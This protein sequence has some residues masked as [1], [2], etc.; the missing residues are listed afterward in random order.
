MILACDRVSIR[1]FSFIGVGFEFPSFKNSCRKFNFIF[2]GVYQL[3]EYDLSKN[4][5]KET[6]IFV[7]FVTESGSFYKSYID[8]DRRIT[9]KYGSVRRCFISDC[10]GGDVNMLPK[11]RKLEFFNSPYF[12]FYAT[13]GFTRDSASILVGNQF[14]QIFE[15]FKFKSKR[16]KLFCSRNGRFN[17]HRIYTIYKLYES[18]LID[19]GIVSALFYDDENFSRTNLEDVNTIFTDKIDSEFYENEVKPNLP[20]AIDDL[21]KFD[22]EY[23]LEVRGDLHYNNDFSD[24]YFDLVTENTYLGDDNVH[25]INTITEK[26]IKPFLYYQI[27][28]FVAQ[29]HLVSNLKQ[30]GFDLFEDLIDI[31]YD[32]MEDSDRIDEAIKILNSLQDLNH[33]RVFS[34]Y[35]KRLQYNKNLCIKLAFE[36]GLSDIFK[37]IL[38]YKLLV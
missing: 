3:D 31:N 21:A 36:N 8:V 24:A 28:I 13:L 9:E 23:G 35:R 17:S 26:T 2:I 14:E 16:N 32:S 6:I 12:N 38:E 10:V 27:P 19:K 22:D 33:C 18:N 4:I 30:L 5:S 20:I 34:K 15:S 11:H 29:K 25:S 7:D 37:F 1:L